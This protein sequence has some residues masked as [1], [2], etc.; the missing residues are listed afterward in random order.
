MKITQDTKKVAIVDLCGS[1]N[2]LTQNM[3]I[4]WNVRSSD[5]K[6]NKTP[7]NV[8][9]TSWILKRLTISG[10]KVNIELYGSLSSSVISKRSSIEKI[11]NILLLR[12]KK[13]LRCGGDL[14]LKKVPQL[15]KI[16]HKKLI[17]K[18]TLNKDNILRVITSDDHVIRVKNEESPT[19][20]WHM[21]KRSR[22]MSAGW[23]ISN[24]DHIGK[25]L[26]PS[27]RSLLKAI[28]GATKMTNH[29]HR[30]RIPKWW[31]HVNILTQLTI[32]KCILYIKLRD[33]LLPNRSHNKKNV[34]N[35]HMNNRSKSLIII[36][37]LLLLKTTSNETSLIALKRTIRVS[38]NTHLQVIGRTHEGQC[39]R[40]HVAVHSRAAIFSA[41]ACC[42]SGWRIT[43]Q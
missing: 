10:C 12:Q 36:M 27:M 38:L 26:K 25:T 11:L 6:V 35:G 21:D 28:K 7:Y 16:R 39:T 41:I 43:S 32:K 40:S 18:M 34:N 8:T 19:T 33:W 24:N 17:T 29:T 5:T 1:R 22:I 30:D 3:Y 14:N 31:A 9:I 20:R 15:T 13:T 2:K 42:H 23:K 4:I 37:T